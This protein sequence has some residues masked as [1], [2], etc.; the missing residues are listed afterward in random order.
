MIKIE[1][2]KETRKY[3]NERHR[4]YIEQT[5][6]QKLEIEIKKKNKRSKFLRRKVKLFRKKKN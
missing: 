4:E 3:I 2:A 6:L 1:M 5:A